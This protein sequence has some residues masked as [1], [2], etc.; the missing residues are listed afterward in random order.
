MAAGDPARL[1]IGYQRDGVL[2][3]AKA[4]GR[5]E[6]ELA[7]AGVRTVEWVLFPSG[8]PLLEAMRAGAIDFGATGE[9]PPI[10]AQA[11]GAA[12]VYVAAEPVTGAGQAL[13]AP[14]ASPVRRVADLRGRSLAFTPGSTSH[15]FALNALREAGLTLRDV[16]A[17]PLAPPDGAAAFARGAVDAWIVWDSFYALAQRDAHARV[18]LTA[19][20]LPPTSSFYIAPRR[21]AEQRPGQLTA[22]LDVLAGVARRGEANQAHATEV[23]AAASGLP[24][25]I[26]RVSRRRGPFEVASLSA[27]LVVHQQAAADTLSDAR[28]IPTRLKVADAVWT[29]WRG[30]T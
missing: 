27:K 20:R 14:P 24:R 11:G 1:R 5:I 26:V 7:R 21:V 13:L 23:I 28:V 12:L 6:A 2:L 15:L 9:T 30:A 17:V 19:E 4:E 10:F 16:K 18:V 8:P 3:L 22:L 25:D 29:G